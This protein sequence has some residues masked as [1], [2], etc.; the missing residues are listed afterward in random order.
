MDVMQLKEFII[1]PSLSKL[2]EKSDALINLLLGTA[3]QESHVGEFIVQKGIGYDGGIGIYQMEAATYHYT[4]TKYV[5]KS[6]SMKSKFRLFLGYEG[7]PLATRLASDTLLA[8]VMARLYYA[9]FPEPLPDA[10]DVKALANYWK[11]YWNTDLGSGYPDQF[12]KNYNKY[13]LKIG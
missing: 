3:A 2:G 12:V 8:T 7:K 10:N 1:K 13:I 9:T 11:K 5:E 6:V 4:Y